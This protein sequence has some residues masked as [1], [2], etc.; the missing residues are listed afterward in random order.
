MRVSSGAMTEDDRHSDLDL[1][2]AKYHTDDGYD[3]HWLIGLHRQ[4]IC[5]TLRADIC[6]Q[7]LTP[8]SGIRPSTQSQ[9]R[10]SSGTSDQTE[11]HRNGRPTKCTMVAAQ[12]ARLG[13][14]MPRPDDAATTSPTI[15]SVFPPG[16]SA[17][18]SFAADRGARSVMSSG[19]NLVGRTPATCDEL[20][21]ETVASRPDSWALT[22]TRRLP[23]RC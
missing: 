7:N 6:K 8:W 15:S 14:G 18:K 23:P 12:P 13:W 16:V 17:F 3:W 5:I 9:T 19:L 4:A 22:P 10:R 1:S 11:A 20:G 2:P 21:S